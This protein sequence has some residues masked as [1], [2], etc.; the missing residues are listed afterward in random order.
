M[1]LQNDFLNLL[2]AHPFIKLFHLS[3]LLQMLNDHT[4]VDVEFFSNF[5]CSCKRISFDYGSQLVLVNF[6]WLATMLFIFKALVSFAKLLEPPLHCMFIAVSGPNALL[7]LQV[8][9]SALQ[10]ILNSRKSLKFALCLT[11]FP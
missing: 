2:L 6:Q 7:M 1:I 5:S 4:T 11:P 8:V 3:N 9:Y 10:P